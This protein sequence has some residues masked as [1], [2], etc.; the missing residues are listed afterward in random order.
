MREKIIDKIT[1][2]NYKK[3][4]ARIISTIFIPPVFCTFLFIFLSY[5]NSLSERELIFN[6]ALSVLSGL[7]LPLAIFIYWRKRGYIGDDDAT[8]KEERVR[9]YLSGIILSLFSGFAAYF[10]ETVNIIYYMWFIYAVVLTLLV[11]INRYWKISAHLIAAAVPLAVYFYFTGN[12]SFWYPL[13]LL[14]IGWSRII[15]KKHTYM[16]VI[17]GAVFG[18]FTTYIQLYFITKISG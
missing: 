6:I 10:Y 16:Q 17:A 12:I 2:K 8:V 15:L 4:V 18:F 3:T 5:G 11:I 9:P 1:D 7:L 13:L 14:L